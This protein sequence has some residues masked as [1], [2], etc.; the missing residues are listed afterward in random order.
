MAEEG[1]TPRVQKWY[2]APQPKG[3]TLYSILCSTF[4]RSFPW[5]DKNATL[6]DFSLTCM[7][8]RTC[9]LTADLILAWT[10]NS[11]KAKLL[12]LL[13][14]DNTSLIP[15]GFA[16]SFSKP[17][18]HSVGRQKCFPPLVGELLKSQKWNCRFHSHLMKT[19]KL[20]LFLKTPKIIPRATQITWNYLSQYM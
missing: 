19:H 20:S 8:S 4:P 14:M 12:V 5:R 1:I 9:S 2:Q 3:I 18:K 15:S 16:F 11:E 13:H 6:K 17:L 10:S 7:Q